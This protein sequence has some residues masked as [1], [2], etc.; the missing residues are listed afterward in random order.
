M[1]RRSSRRRGA[2]ASSGNFIKSGAVK[3]GVRIVFILALSLLLSG[4][5]LYSWMKSYLHSEDFRL[6]MGKNV[7]SLVGGT[8]EFG[9]FVWQGMDVQTKGLK[10]QTS[11]FLKTLEAN[12][13]RASLSLD[14]VRRG[15]WEISDLRANELNVNFVTLGVR[16]KL[17]REE[18]NEDFQ[19]L[20]EDLQ[21]GSSEENQKSGGWL[22]GLLPDRAELM[23]ADVMHTN[24][25][26]QMVDGDMRFR[27]T[28]MRVDGGMG[29]KNFDFY[30]SDGSVELPWLDTA[31]RLK[32]ARGKYQHGRL[33]LTE[34]QMGIYER[35]ELT[36]NGEL[37]GDSFGWFG[38]VRDV[39][40]DEVVPE[41]WKKSIMGNIE[42]DFKV[43]RIG[44]SNKDVVT[45]G[46]LTL[47]QGVLTALPVLDRIAAYANNRRFRRLDLSECHFNFRKSGD[48]LDLTDIVIASEGLI[49]IKGNLSIE[50]GR[51]NGR[52]RVGIM[53][54]I[55]AHIPGAETKVFLRGEKGL[56]WTPLRITGTV[57]APKEDLS[58][59]MI[60]AAG[61]RMFEMIPETGKMALKFAHETATQLPGKVLES[62]SDLIQGGTDVIQ[63]GGDVIEKGVRGVLELLP[64]G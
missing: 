15:V 29:G 18:K 52:F 38:K 31:L 3:W 56:L 46:K 6:F 9:P 44:G 4:F 33:F 58:Q 8:A 55:L 21:A 27:D 35:G 23:S 14:G 40:C 22:S 1:S 50:N 36:L 17:R 63:K 26:I 47:K 30:F 10:V 28:V 42:S 19:K 11:G 54:G 60:Q 41:S 53:P 61:E 37:E 25:N 51:L 7:G 34:S 48:T 43:S 5:G 13:V 64:G 16:E 49:R 12:G 57:D 24:I 45:R 59:R 2:S 62:G 32:S 39:R 20:Q